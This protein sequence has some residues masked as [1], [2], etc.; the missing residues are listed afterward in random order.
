MFSA[1][2]LIPESHI[3]EFQYHAIDIEVEMLFSVLSFTRES[4]SD[5]IEIEPMK[6]K[7]KILWM[8]SPA[9]EQ[10][11]HFRIFL[12]SPAHIFTDFYLRDRVGEKLEMP[13]PCHER[14][15]L[16]E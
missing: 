12:Y 15:E 1:P 9:L 3:V 14:I 16:P 6:T 13:T 8:E 10:I 4:L 11:Y 5:S 7:W 2:E